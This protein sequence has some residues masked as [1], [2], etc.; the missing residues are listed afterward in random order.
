MLAALLT[1]QKRRSLKKINRLQDG[2]F[3][4]GTEL[5]NST[6]TSLAIEPRLIA[7]DSSLL[8][9]PAEPESPTTT[10]FPVDRRMSLSYPPEPTDDDDDEPYSST[11][12]YDALWFLRHD[13]DAK[14]KEHSKPDY[15]ESEFDH[16]IREDHNKRIDRK[17]VV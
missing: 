14:P 16:K 15:E 11:Q 6:D 8:C 2:V 13:F 1:Q 5:S 17:S 9:V 10:T 4:F 12:I 7:P 3:A